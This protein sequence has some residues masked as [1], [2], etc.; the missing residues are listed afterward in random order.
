MSNATE[1]VKTI[2]TL[3]IE[4]LQ[5]LTPLKKPVEE[6]VITSAFKRSALDRTLV[7]LKALVEEDKIILSCEGPLEPIRY[8]MSDN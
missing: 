4:L 1:N 7:A 8:Q 6:T 3:K 5:Y 2:S